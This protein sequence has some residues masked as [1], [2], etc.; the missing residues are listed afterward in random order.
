[1]PHYGA[2]HVQPDAAILH[3]YRVSVSSI[4]RFIV[5]IRHV[6]PNKVCEFG[7]DDCV[8]APS[9]VDRTAHRY[10]SRLTDRV[11]MM[12]NKL[13]QRCNLLDLPSV[14]TKGAEE[15]NS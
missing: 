1:M 4:Y 8:Q 3:H 10:A 2:L 9:T 6:T 7:G 5:F 15:L 12:Y 13:K 14:P 11:D